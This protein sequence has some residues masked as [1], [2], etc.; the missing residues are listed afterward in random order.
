MDAPVYRNGELL[1]IILDDDNFFSGSS[2]NSLYR[3][4]KTGIKVTAVYRVSP[5][6]TFVIDYDIESSVYSSYPNILQDFT[7]S[8]YLQQVAWNQYTYYRYTDNPLTISYSGSEDLLVS[9]TDSINSTS[10]PLGSVSIPV[11]Y[12]FGVNASALNPGGIPIGGGN[13]GGTVVVVLDSTSLKY[14]SCEAVSLAVE[15]HYMGFG[16]GRAFEDEKANIRDMIANISFSFDGQHYPVFSDS[17]TGAGSKFSSVMSF[18]LDSTFSSPVSP[19]LPVNIGYS[20]S[21]SNP[22][23]EIFL[24]DAY[25]GLKSFTVDNIVPY[26]ARVWKGRYGVADP[27]YKTMYVYTNYSGDDR[28]ISSISGN[29]TVNISSD[30][31]PCG[32]RLMVYIRRNVVSFW[33][34]VVND[35]NY[36]RCNGV[37]VL[38]FSNIPNFRDFRLDFPDLPPISMPDKDFRPNSYFFLEHLSDPVDPNQNYYLCTGYGPGEFFSVEKPISDYRYQ[39]R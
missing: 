16:D 19:I 4:L 37:P 14:K 15:L 26:P 29:I 11:Q 6:D 22:D 35:K 33:Y 27:Y 36:T 31:L 2:G 8:N 5:I 20:V 25:H 34:D 13:N 32:N 38:P 17:I 10:V 12:Y 7:V 1:E 18:H 30:S 3:D 21:L 9:I 23:Y 24:V 28:D 39:R